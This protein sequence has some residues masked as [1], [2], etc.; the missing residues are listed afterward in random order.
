VARAIKATMATIAERFRL[1]PKVSPMNG[2]APV[3]VSHAYAY[4]PPPS[5]AVRVRPI[6]V[7]SVG[8]LDVDD[9]NVTRR[10]SARV[11]AAATLDLR[12]SF[13]TPLYA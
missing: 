7:V 12:T 8:S 6:A 13:V 9:D 10:G 2:R 1:L 4:R 5:L 3:R 11:T